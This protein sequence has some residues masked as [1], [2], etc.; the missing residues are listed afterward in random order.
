MQLE[1]VFI[2]ASE[3][4]NLYFWILFQKIMQAPVQFRAR[5]SKLVG[6]VLHWVVNCFFYPLLWK[7]LKRIYVQQNLYPN[8]KLI[9]ICVQSL[10]SHL[11]FLC[12]FFTSCLLPR[13]LGS[14]DQNKQPQNTPTLF[15]RRIWLF[16]EESGLSNSK[17]KGINL[18]WWVYCPV[19]FFGN[20]VLADVIS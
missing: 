2:V 5:V 16:K 9:K 20:M 15:P 14:T 11:A 18:K 8:Y 12:L 1:I 10:P 13:L 19:A 17:S 3:I 7:L 6:G 4:Y